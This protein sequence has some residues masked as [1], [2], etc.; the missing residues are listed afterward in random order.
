MVKNNKLSFLLILFIFLLFLKVDFRITNDLVCCGD[1][2]DYFAHAAT[3]VED[4]DFDY[5]NQLPDKSRYYKNEK[6]APIGFFGTGLLSVPFLALGKLFDFFTEDQ[7]NGILAY[8]E[9]IYS[10]SSI[11]YLFLTLLYIKKILAFKNININKF[12]LPFFGS[13]IIYYA[14]ERYSMTHVYEVFS[15]T[16][17]IYFSIC[18]F[19]VVDFAF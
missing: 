18:Y 12:V 14:F 3:I 19:F 15:V 5:S 16:M 9:L 17:V 10:F 7:S 4:L 6:N 13:G 2:Y 11:F 1:D 8:E